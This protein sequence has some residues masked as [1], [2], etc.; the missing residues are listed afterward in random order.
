MNRK[1]ILTQHLL[2]SAALAALCGAL[3]ACAT[4]YTDASDANHVTF[5]QTTNESRADLELKAKAYCLQYGKK[6]VYKE[7]E[8][9]MITVF[10]CN[11]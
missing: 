10:N 6:A 9:F 3:S 2:R 8:G 1:A 5:I 7:T 4:I 11:P